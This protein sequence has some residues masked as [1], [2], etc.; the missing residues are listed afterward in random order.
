MPLQLIYFRKGKLMY[1]N[2]TYCV[3]VIIFLNDKI[4]NKSLSIL[5]LYETIIAYIIILKYKINSNNVEMLYELVVTHL[6]S[7]NTNQISFDAYFN[8]LI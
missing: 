1:I 6:K 8:T 7:C 4:F 2:T 3:Y 5:I